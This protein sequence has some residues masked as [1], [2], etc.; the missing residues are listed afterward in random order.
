MK[1]TSRKR[2]NS[3]GFSLVELIVVIAIMAV[4][5]GVLAPTLI[6][7]VEKSRRA[8][9]MANAKQINTVLTTALIEGD[10]DIPAGRRNTGYGAWVMICKDKSKAP[11]TYRYKNFKNVWCGVDAGITVNG[12]TTHDETN[13]SQNAQLIEILEENGLN[14][15]SLKSTSNGG[16]NGWDWIIIEVYYDK[17]GNPGSRIYSGFSNENGGI[18]NMTAKTNIEK[19]MNGN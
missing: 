8:K 18:N 1:K 19:Q 14:L 3:A 7:N 2:L 15:D 11:S 10:I 17:D 16:S 12:Y 5:V 9:D 6:R 13:A 4:L